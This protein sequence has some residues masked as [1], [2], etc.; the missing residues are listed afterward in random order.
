MLWAQHLHNCIPRDLSITN[1]DG[2]ETFCMAHCPVSCPTDQQ[3]CPGGVSWDGC[4]NPDHCMP[5]Q[6]WD[7]CPAHCEPTCDW[8][9]G[10]MFCHGEW[11]AA[12]G[13]YGP[14]YC[15]ADGCGAAGM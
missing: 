3:I 8:S 6:N 11:D 1:E 14:S 7:G 12:T 4:P 5:K 15:S 9:K 10:E 13:C 2:T